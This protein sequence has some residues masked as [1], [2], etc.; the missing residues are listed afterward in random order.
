MVSQKLK[1]A[2]RLHRMKAYEI[3]HEAGLHPSTLSRLL[4]GIEIPRENDQRVIR[5]GRVV[6]VADLDCFE[7]GGGE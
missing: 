4:C 6:G 5:I 7:Q 1:N 2:V 3:A